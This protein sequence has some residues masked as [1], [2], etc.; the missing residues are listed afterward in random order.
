MKVCTSSLFLPTKYAYQTVVLNN[1]LLN[2]KEK[3]TLANKQK[4]D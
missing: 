4:I 1:Y 3:T 2:T